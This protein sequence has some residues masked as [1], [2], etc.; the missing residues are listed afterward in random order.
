MPTVN[1][2]ACRYQAPLTIKIYIYIY[3]PSRFPEC[4]NAIDQ[5]VESWPSSDEMQVLRVQQPLILL[6]EEVALTKN[7]HT[8]SQFLQKSETQLTHVAFTGS[9]S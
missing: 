7:C 8:Y 3:V 9:A 6:M 1:P 5:T 4:S 2:W